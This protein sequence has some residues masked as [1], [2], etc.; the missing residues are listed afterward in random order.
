ME[1]VLESIEAYKHGHLFACLSIRSG[2]IPKVKDEIEL[3]QQFLLSAHIIVNIL[4]DNNLYFKLVEQILLY[5][6]YAAGLVSKRLEWVDVMEGSKTS[7][8]KIGRAIIQSIF[9][10][11]QH[12]R[13]G[14]IFANKVK[15]PARFD[16]PIPFTVMSGGIKTLAQYIDEKMFFL[17]TTIGREYMCAYF[18]CCTLKI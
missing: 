2:D 18:M 4:L 9:D 16:D 17:K 11:I 6:A 1:E 12:D 8:N 14:N 5:F 3:L 13:K 10:K 15:R 7:E